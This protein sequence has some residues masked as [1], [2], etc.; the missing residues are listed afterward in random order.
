MFGLILITLLIFTSGLI[1]Y[2]GDKI[3]RN[4]GKKKLSLLGIRP[5]NTAIIISITS[6]ILITILTIAI[7]SLVSQTARDA[8]FRIEYIQ[9]R[10]KNL[11]KKLKELQAEY[12]AQKNKLKEKETEIKQNEA[13]AKILNNNIKNKNLNLQKLQQ[14]LSRVQSQEK[15]VKNQLKDIFKKYVTE[16]N[17]LTRSK[18]ELNKLENIRKDLKNKLKELAEQRIFL[19]EKIESLRNQGNDVFNRL[20]EV[21]QKYQEG[22]DKLE[23]LEKELAQ[24]K[25]EL[26]TYKKS[27]AQITSKNKPQIIIQKDEILSKI[28]IPFNFTSAQKRKFILQAISK[29]NKVALKKGAQTLNKNEAVIFTSEQF[30]EVILKLQNTKNDAILEITAKAAVLKYNPVSL[31]F[32]LKINAV[33]IKSGEILAE[34]FVNPGTSVTNIQ[35]YLIS[36]M[37]EARKFAESKGVKLK[38]QEVV[39][40]D[41]KEFNSLTNLMALANTKLQVQILAKR[42]IFTIDDL[43]IYIHVR[44]AEQ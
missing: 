32:N 4:I 30:Q 25:T 16:K 34:G 23:I 17:K 44:E 15:K 6:G 42:D 29:A 1:A 3:G 31:N 36:L 28:F 26:D 2:L 12:K 40:V 24:T 27:Q 37:A 11:Q 35:T 41:P 18:K 39:G 19:E 7:I 21:Q 20:A 9:T 10:T 14:K 22:K 38:N 5:R 43:E 13:T 8:L 33:I